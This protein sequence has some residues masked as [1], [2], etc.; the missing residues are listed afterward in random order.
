MGSHQ[1]LDARERV[2]AETVRNISLT[3]LQV[4]LMDL[5]K[6]FQWLLANI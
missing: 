3:I 1:G 5:P 6:F 2:D 4:L